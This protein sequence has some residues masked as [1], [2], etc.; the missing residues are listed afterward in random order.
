MCHKLRV[1]PCDNK[2][3]TPIQARGPGSPLAL[4]N[5]FHMLSPVSYCCCRISAFN[6]WTPPNPPSHTQLQSLL[7]SWTED[8][9]QFSGQ[10]STPS[11]I[12]PYLINPNAGTIINT[13]WC[14]G[15]RLK[16]SVQLQDTAPKPSYASRQPYTSCPFCC[17]QSGLASAPS[18]GPFPGLS[19]MPRIP[20]SQPLPG[21][22]SCLSGIRC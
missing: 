17:S 4:P 20:S 3:I 18:P 10:N 7:A 16:L 12:W 2:D 14:M 9:W 11:I 21:Q 1:F 13:S 22:C 6:I 19:Q 5:L 15:N 8:K